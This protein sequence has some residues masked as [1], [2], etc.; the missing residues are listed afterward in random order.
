LVRVRGGPGGL[1][2]LGGKVNPN[3]GVDGRIPSVTPQ[4]GL[5]VTLYAD[6]AT[7]NSASIVK[8]RYLNTQVNPPGLADEAGSADFVNFASGG[9]PWACHGLL[10]ATLRASLE[11]NGVTRTAWLDSAR[12]I[13][14]SHLGA[15]CDILEFAEKCRIYRRSSAER[16]TRGTFASAAAKPSSSERAP[17]RYGVI[18]Q[19]VFYFGINTTDRPI[20][21]AGVLAGRILETE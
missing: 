15:P 13:L 6:V 12:I 21:E 4:D 5:I 1:N 9:L 8:F 3:G 14:G 17:Y 2:E 7:E 11:R 20:K 19:K 10:V 16:F 18:A